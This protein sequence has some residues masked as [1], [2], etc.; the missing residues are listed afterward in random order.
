MTVTDFGSGSLPRTDA[1]VE[2]SLLDGGSFIGDLS[3]LHAGESGGFRMYN[4]AFYISHRGR[5]IIWDLGLDE[6][7][8]CYT[9]W[10][11]QFMLDQ[12]NHVG[13]RRTIVQQ[14]SERGVLANQ[15][16]TVLF[17]HAHWDHSRPI[18]DVFPNATAYFGPGTRSACSPGH[19]EEPNAQWDGR[20]FDPNHATERWEEVAGTWAKF[21]P[22]NVAMDYFGD[23]SFWVIQSPGHMP[24]NLSAAARL[25][26]GSWVL[27]GSDCC[28]SRE[29]LDGKKEIAQFGENMSLHTDLNAAKDTIAKIRTLERGCG[30]HVA[31]AHDASWLKQGSD[32]V[33]MS[34]L[35]DYM[36]A[37]V[38]EGRIA[39]DEIP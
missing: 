5:H 12:V 29:L 22:F 13:P 17:S 38:K 24:G 25:R 18:S 35:D 34:L 37:A 27:L 3:R 30:L 4:W 20:F 7:R 39:R 31:L 16:D 36:K 32:S 33:L 10:V 8:S 23:G 19:L 21:G 15:I 26:D 11:N 28:H 2:L 1:F 9:P 14:L 6:D